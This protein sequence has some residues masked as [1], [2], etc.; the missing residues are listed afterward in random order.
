[1]KI[2]VFIV[3]L[4]LIFAVGLTSA[5]DVDELYVPRNVQNALNNGTRS[6][7]GQPGENYWQNHSS[8]TMTINVAPPDRSVTATQH[9][10]YTNN[11]PDTLPY[12]TFRLYLNFHR[13]T[14]V[15]E[16]AVTAD[17]IN[18]GIVVNEFR[19][20]GE[21]VEWP[22][23]VS[24]LAKVPLPEPLEPGGSA[25]F[26]F[27][28]Q[29]EPS[30]ENWKEGVV[31]DTTYY[32][33]YF[34]P[35]LAVYD[36]LDG[37]ETS[38]FSSNGR[39][40]YNDFSDFSFEV[41]L[42]PNF[43]MWATGDLLNPEEVL[44]P[45]YNQRLQDSFTSDDVIN[46]AQPEELQEGLVTAQDDTVTWKW[47]AD[48]VVDIAMGISNN[49]IWDAGSVVVDTDTG[50]RASVQA[51]YRPDSEAFKTMVEDGKRALVYGSTEY[52]G[53]PYPYP[54]TTIFQGDADEEYPMMANDAEDP[55][56]PL[57]FPIL[58]P[59]VA[60]H[61]ILHSWFPFYMG[62]NE[63]RYPMMDEG[64][65]TFFEYSYLLEFYGEGTDTEFYNTVNWFGTPVTPTVF[66]I[67]VRMTQ[68]A[69]DLVYADIPIIT[70]FDSLREG[71]WGDNNYGKPALAYH[72]LNELMGK[73]AFLAA[74][75][76][77][78]DRWN[79]K[80]P[81]P[82]DLFNTFNDVADEDLTWFF[83]RWYFEPNYLDLALVDVQASDDGYDLQVENIGGIPM[84][85]DVLIVYADGTQE[86]IRQNPAIWRESNTVSIHA[87]TSG[88]VQ[89]IILDGGIYLEGHQANN[90]WQ[91]S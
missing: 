76:E 66:Y 21:V 52:P 36:D 17:F 53:V 89:Q 75:H 3:S 24:T 59:W 49:F 48:N 1:M 9:I 60:A 35:R 64:I 20:N 51:A 90:V 87:P 72:A 5:Q 19:I 45:E 31:N 41:N 91:N 77:F 42:P 83:Q 43:V 23:P 37:W 44:Q 4:L 81:I 70:P 15:R 29:F 30:A 8:H 50:R 14:A 12:V 56:Y 84:P 79:G 16:S 46:I 73:E 63:S 10:V 33:A 86:R 57:E 18:D 71:Y 34:F 40:Y 67:Y 68:W 27:D 58:A 65:V 62:T 80:H 38:E 13:P 54:K 32:L 47:Q 88:E 69:Q 25:T 85:F 82:W 28:W 39:E 22:E 7:D 78:M 11:S 2:K 6:L 61:E 26:D 74:L 55:G